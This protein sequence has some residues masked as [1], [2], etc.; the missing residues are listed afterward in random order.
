MKKQNFFLFLS[1][2]CLYVHMHCHSLFEH[3]YLVQERTNRM[4]PTSIVSSRALKRKSKP[5]RCGVCVCVCVFACM[6]ACADQAQPEQ[7]A[8]SK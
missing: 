3:T 7:E 5:L 4:I 6:R 1:T 2:V 8:T